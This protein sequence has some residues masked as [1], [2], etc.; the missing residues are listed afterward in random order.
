MAA[1][2]PKIYSG[3]RMDIHAISGDRVWLRYFPGEAPQYPAWDL[4]FSFLLDTAVL[5]T[6]GGIA[7]Y[8]MFIQPLEDRVPP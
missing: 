1:G 4:P 3:T 6:T 8:E 5:P 2:T 7:A